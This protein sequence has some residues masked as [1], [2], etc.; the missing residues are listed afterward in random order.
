[1]KLS[2]LMQGK[3]PNPKFEGFTTADDMVLAIDFSAGEATDTKDFVVAQNGI[4]GQSGSLTPQ[5]KDSQYLRTGQVTL[6]TGTS[7]AF[8]VTG[9]RYVNDEFQDELLAYKLKFGTGQEV[10]KPYLYFNLLT[11]KGERGKV[12]IVVEDDLSGDAGDNASFSA[13][14]TSTK[15]PEEWTYP[16]SAEP[17]DPGTGGSDPGDPGDTGSDPG[18]P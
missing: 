17:A 8:K 3:T 13:T 7:R 11:G 6:K 1:M 15:K 16:S 9:D 2:E 18:E 5:T 10:I 4:K 14:L 12:S